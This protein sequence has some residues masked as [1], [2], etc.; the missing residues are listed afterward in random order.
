MAGYTLTARDYRGS[1]VLVENHDTR[2]AAEARARHLMS[3]AYAH[4]PYFPGYH[5]EAEAPFHS[6]T[7]E[8]AQAQRRGRASGYVYGVEGRSSGIR[9]RRA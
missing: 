3:E 5:A 2:K 8:K 9:A 1:I 6:V 4:Q 7:V